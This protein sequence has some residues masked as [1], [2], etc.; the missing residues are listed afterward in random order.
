MVKLGTTCDRPI[1]NVH[2]YPTFIAAAGGTP[3]ADLDGVSLLPLFKGST[4]LQR[5]SVFWHFPGYLDNAVPRGRDPV[6]RT[7]PVSVIR[8]GDWKLH[9]EQL[10]TNHAVELYNIATDIGERSEL[11]LKETKKRDELLGELL[12]WMDRTKAPLAK[13]PTP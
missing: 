9:R 7:R 6:F 5:E 12:V 8:K 1:I 4:T 13:L 10:A 3:A 11:A 2:L